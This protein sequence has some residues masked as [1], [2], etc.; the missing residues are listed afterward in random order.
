[1]LFNSIEDIPDS[2]VNKSTVAKTIN[3][4]GHNGI[5]SKMAPILVM[6]AWS[7]SAEDWDTYGT[8]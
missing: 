6:D 8:H 3:P 5:T 7:T 4:V 1:M 2:V